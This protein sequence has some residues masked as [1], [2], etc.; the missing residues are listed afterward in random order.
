[1]Q[2]VEEPSRRRWQPHLQ[3][4]DRHIPHFQMQLLHVGPVTSR[5]PP[6]LREASGV[7]WRS[8]LWTISCY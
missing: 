3:T 1:M 2:K 8:G 7:E 4:A 6:L 5:L